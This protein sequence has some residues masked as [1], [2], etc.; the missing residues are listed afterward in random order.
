M[1][2]LLDI[3]T[4]PI[5]SFDEGYGVGKSIETNEWLFGKIKYS[6]ETHLYS[7]NDIPVYEKSVGKQSDCL[8]FDYGKTKFFCEGQFVMFSFAGDPDPKILGVCE[9]DDDW[10]CY[11]A[12]KGKRKI[13]LKHLCN[14]IEQEIDTYYRNDM[15]LTVG[16]YLFDNPNFDKP[17]KK[18][19]DGDLPF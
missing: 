2:N 17:P 6:F 12:R 3:Y 13:I 14:F 11:V 8:I 15:Y 19:I 4:T 5:T 16:G 9:Y 10:G 18:E 7:V 1:A